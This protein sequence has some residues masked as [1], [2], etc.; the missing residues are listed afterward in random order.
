MASLADMIEEYI[1]SLLKEGDGVAEIQRTMLA[2]QF[3]CVPS[4]ITYVLSSRFSPERGY[5]VESKR[6]GGGYIRVVKVNLEDASQIVSSIGPC[7][8]QEEAYAYL[9]RLLD[10]GYIERQAYE[11]MKAALSRKVLAIDLPVR[12]YI[13]ANIFKAMLNAYFS[14]PKTRS[15]GYDV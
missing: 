10:G 15:D 2:S 9:D 3:R 12:D 5:I 14:A 6:G 11:M 4:Q 7:I 13:R 1:L 8:S